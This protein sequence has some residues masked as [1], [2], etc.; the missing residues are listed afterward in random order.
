MDPQLLSIHY[1]DPL[2]IAIAFLCGLAIR[3]V[4]L[5][6]MVGFLAAGFALKALGAEGDE[7]LN[8][9]ADLGITL[10]LFSI[11]LKLKL[12]ALARPV[13]RWHWLVQGAVPGGFFPQRWHDRCAGLDRNLVGVEIEQEKATRHSSEGRN[14]VCGDATNLG[15]WIRAPN[16]LDRLEWISLTLSTHKANMNAALRLKEMGYR[17]HIAATTKFHD[18]EN[19]LEG[20]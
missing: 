18:E 6:P 12:K 8:V 15:F 11:G 14:V 17:G 20:Y 10:L 7:F 16:L 5:P 19:A 4:G 3:V 13:S 2:W 1:S 9:M